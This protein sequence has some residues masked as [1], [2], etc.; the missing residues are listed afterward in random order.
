MTNHEDKALLERLE[1]LKNEKPHQ[2]LL[3]VF[4][5]KPQI[6]ISIDYH[7][8]HRTFAD[9]MAFKSK[10]QNGED[11]KD[12][13][14]HPDDEYG[15]FCRD[16]A[17]GTFGLVLEPVCGVML[18]FPAEEA[19]ELYRQIMD[20][21]SML[22]KETADCT[23]ANTKPYIYAGSYTDEE[24]ISFLETVV[25]ELKCRN[26][27]PLRQQQLRHELEAYQTEIDRNNEFL[28]SVVYR[29][30]KNPKQNP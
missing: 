23:C 2:K 29:Q 15:H 12:A 8:L 4:P 26:K 17:K 30:D 21:E 1:T 10:L 5:G 7:E 18:R 9:L 14:L 27:L 25:A 19:F 28:N 16:N 11:L 20:D 13:T 6:E 3:L 22:I 24:L